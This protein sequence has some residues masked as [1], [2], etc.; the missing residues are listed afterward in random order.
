MRP[1]DTGGTHANYPRDHTRP[2]A[3]GLVWDIG[4]MAA[5]DVV[6]ATLELSGTVGKKAACGSELSLT[7]EWSATA[8]AGAGPVK[9]GESGP[10]TVKVGC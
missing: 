1:N 2:L 7:G 4:I 10:L 3:G 8:N 9:Y 6:T 5:G